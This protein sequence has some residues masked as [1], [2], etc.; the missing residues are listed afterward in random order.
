MSTQAQ[1]SVWEKRSSQSIEQIYPGI[2]RFWLAKGQIVCYTVTTIARPAIDAWTEATMEL[3]M[4][5]PKDHI[6]LSIHDFS[7]ATLTPYVRK[8]AEEANSKM[9]KT[10]YGRSAVIMPRTFMNHMIRLFVTV[11]LSRKNLRIERDV[12][13]RL[14]EATE[15]LKKALEEPT[16]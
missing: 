7:E 11:E 3:A 4:A 10:L 2:T 14:E 16:A 15:W 12:F 1:S 5:W 8:R 6:Y 9:P 13:F